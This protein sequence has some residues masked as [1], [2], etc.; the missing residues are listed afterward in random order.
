MINI[1]KA[2]A[3]LLSVGMLLSSGASAFAAFAEELETEEL[4]PSGES[5]AFLKK[6]VEEADSS[7]DLC[8]AQSLTVFRGDEII[9]HYTAGYEDIENGIPADSDTVFDWASISKVLIWVSA[10]QLYEQ[11]RL[12]LDADI[13]AYLPDG[14]LRRLKYDD[15]IS[16]INLMNHTGGWSEP[17]YQ[18]ILPFEDRDKL[19]PLDKAL[20]YYEPRQVYRP[21]EIVAYSNWGSS[22]AAYVIERISGMDYAEYVR[23][24]IFEPLGMEHTSVAAD[25]SDNQWVFERRMKMPA[26][27]NTDPYFS[28]E[29]V[30]LKRNGLYFA[31][32]PCGSAVGTPADLVRFAQAFVSDECPLFENNS[33]RDMFFKGTSFCGDS[34]IMSCS[35]GLWVTQGNDCA[36][37]GHTGFSGYNIS[38]MEFDPVSKYGYAY[39]THSINEYESLIGYFFG[40]P[41]SESYPADGGALPDISGY[42]VHA[43]GRVPG[44]GIE[45]LISASKF[46]F[47]T[48]ESISIESI[49]G[50]AYKM[51]DPESGE[52]S[53]IIAVNTL[54]DGSKTLSMPDMDFRPVSHYYPKLLL[55]TAYFITAAAAIFMLKI[56]RRM[57][58]AGRLKFDFS[59]AVFAA[60]DVMRLLSV[61]LILV[62]IAFGMDET[63]CAIP[64]IVTII[65]GIGHT[66]F[67]IF[68]IAAAVVSAIKAY[69]S[70]KAPARLAVSL[71][72]CLA[73]VISVA[74]VLAFKLYW[75]TSC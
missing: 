73:N 30:R 61:A 43:R 23:K 10:L 59:E 52:I 8:P 46:D 25:F 24:N 41:Q 2:A 9:A 16:M 36:A 62:R 69:R 35:Y 28:G 38:D 58:I 34:D 47:E 49:G 17:L 22:L 63:A 70:R 53:Y 31:V 19:M 27:K 48:D 29:Y 37:F 51:T 7:D 13:R 60:A 18:D 74:A 72:I 65:H 11:G 68:F 32:Y 44:P 66:L 4:L 42:Y 20:Q 45:E 26:Y 39:M 33:T 64:D 1:K 5:I 75:F 67:L 15:K 56:K 71:I 54:S 6:Q 57:C 3:F 12:D 21:G 50:N 55:L 14:F 40:Y